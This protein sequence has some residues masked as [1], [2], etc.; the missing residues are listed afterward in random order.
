MNAASPG[1]LIRVYPGVYSDPLN[2]EN[3]SDLTI[4]GFGADSTI[5]KPASL[6]A[7]NV[8]GYTTRKAAIRLVGSTNIVFNGIKLDLDIVKGN[9]VSGML[10]WDSTGALQRSTLINNQMPDNDGYYYETGIRVRTA[11]PIYTK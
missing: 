2:I 5:L 9:D 4:Q 1:D 7:W 3:K 11:S 6:L 10:L 8:G